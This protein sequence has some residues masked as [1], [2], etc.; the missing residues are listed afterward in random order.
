MTPK[1]NKFLSKIL[2][3]KKSHL[4]FICIALVLSIAIMSAQR[5]FNT[6]LDNELQTTSASLLTADLEIASTTPL[7]TNILETMEK[8]LP[9]FIVSKRTILSTMAQFN[10]QQ[11]SKLIEVTFT[12][13]CAFQSIIIFPYDV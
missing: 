5:F 13:S 8:K 7:D 12:L 10:Q 4:I 9:S 6:T 11:E 1:L 2:S 3:F